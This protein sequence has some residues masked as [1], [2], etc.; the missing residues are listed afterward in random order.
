MTE[1]SPC[2][3]N[4]IFLELPI[5]RV[6]QFKGTKTIQEPNIYKNFGKRNE[7]SKEAIFG[8]ANVQKTKFPIYV[9]LAAA[10]FTGGKRAQWRE[11]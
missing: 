2:S 10:N 9:L 3:V 11:V 7:I 4:V 8:P 1:E 6:V 5:I